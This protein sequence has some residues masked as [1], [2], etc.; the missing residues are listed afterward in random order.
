MNMIIYHWRS[1]IENPWQAKYTVPILVIN[2]LGSA[3]GYYW[4]AEQLAST[5]KELWL[6]VPDSPLATTM[7][8]AVLLLSLLGFRNVLFSVI[9]LT[10]CIK[11]GLWAVI[12]ISHFWATG[13]G[14]RFPEA[15]LWVSHLGM[16]VQGMIYL[17]PCLFTGSRAGRRFITGRVVAVTASWMLLNDFL[18]YYLDIHPYL[19][20]P[21]QE[22][23]ALVAVVGLSL[24]LILSIKILPFVKMANNSR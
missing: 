21:G 8:A 4:Y 11:Y 23:L 14:I 22:G 18:D 12:I 6:F 13:G 9:A 7:F 15:M 10:A 24:V 19:Y 1:L 2:I 20:E 5:D 16:A 3:Y 17:G